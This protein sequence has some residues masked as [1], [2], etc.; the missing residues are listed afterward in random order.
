MTQTKKE[1]LSSNREWKASAFIQRAIQ[2]CSREDIMIDFINQ[3]GSEINNMLY[4]QFNMEDAL[5]IR[6]EEEYDDG[7]KAGLA[8]GRSEG[9]SK[10]ENLKLIQQVTKKAQKGKT[11]SQIAD[12]LE[13]DI[14]V[15]QPICD[16]AAECDFD[17]EIIYKR[18]YL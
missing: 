7:L 4:T 16:I 10:G 11:P 3:Y 6:G 18:L 1:T 15:I 9:L 14:S 2:D 5:R 12:D 13:E 8:Q 17:S